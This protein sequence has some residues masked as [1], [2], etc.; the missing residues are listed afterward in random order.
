MAKKF[1]TYTTAFFAM[2]RS[3]KKRRS[4]DQRFAAWAEK[5]IRPALRELFAIVADYDPGANTV[6][7]LTFWNDTIGDRVPDAD[8]NDRS[9]VVCIGATHGGDLFVVAAPG[10]KSEAVTTIIHD[11]GWCDGDSWAD[12]EEFLQ[13]RVESYR[14]SQ[15]EDNPD[16]ESEWKTDLDPF[17]ASK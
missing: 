3:G 16:D 7:D 5:E 14:E 1:G 4:T 11:D 15:Q 8:D 10:K 2:L 6:G 17:L 9:D 12:L 13:N